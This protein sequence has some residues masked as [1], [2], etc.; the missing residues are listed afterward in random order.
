MK[1]WCKTLCKLSQY[2]CRHRDKRSEWRRKLADSLPILLDKSLILPVY[3]SK[4]FFLTTP[5]KIFVAHPC[6]YFRWKK[7]KFRHLS[8]FD[9]FLRQATKWAWWSSIIETSPLPSR[10]W[11]SLKKFSFRLNVDWEVDKTKNGA[12]DKTL[13]VSKLSLWLEALLHGHN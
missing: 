10:P 4:H 2:Y 11:D 13:K 12:F 9:K 7:V 5:R 8:L 6:Y 1:K 3:K